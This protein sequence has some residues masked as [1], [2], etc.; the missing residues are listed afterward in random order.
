MNASGIP[1]C[2]CSCAAHLPL[3]AAPGSTYA[4][5]ASLGMT[6]EGRPRPALA[7]LPQIK[8][9][10]RFRDLIALAQGEVDPEVPLEPLQPVVGEDVFARR[11][12]PPH[13]TVGLGDELDD[14]PAAQGGEEGRQLRQR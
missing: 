10:P 14:Q 4:S 1:T 3:R 5:L 13:L 2:T 9:A 12:H 8:C 11:H 7:L 6:T